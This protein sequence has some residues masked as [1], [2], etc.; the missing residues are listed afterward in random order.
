MGWYGMTVVMLCWLL[1]GCSHDQ[2]EDDNSSEPAVLNIYVYTPDSPI[3]TR[4]NTDFVNPMTGRATIYSLQ[5]WVF[6]HENGEQVGYYEPASISDLNLTKSA[7]Y[8]MAVSS[9]FARRKPNVDVY[10]LANIKTATCGCEFDETT[11]RDAL[12]AALLEHAEG[13]TDYFGLSARIMAVPETGLPV[14][15]VLK[16]QKVTGQNPVL[17]VGD[18]ALATVQ[19]ARAVSKVRFLFSQL[20]NADEVLQINRITLNGEA[21]P[22]QEYL[23]LEGPYSGTECHLG[24]GGYESGAVVMA[25]DVGVVAS[26]DDPLNYAFN[27]Q[28]AQ[29]YENLI[30]S[31]LQK[32]PAELTEVGPFYLRESDRKLT[33]TIYYQVNADGAERSANFSMADDGDFTRNHTWIVYAYYG[34]STLEVFVVRMNAW[35]VD[36]TVNHEV[37]NW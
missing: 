18:G 37:Y 14:T 9:D 26:N 22:K 28:G 17:R 7:V 1:C 24:P 16:D 19:L 31:G 21:I 12:D 34:S 8:Q 6:E 27:I 35:T 30:N 4:G 5:L 11:T 3:V 15:G 20:E 32:S 33:G 10:V 13:G 29:E 23:M 36:E 2:D 25:S